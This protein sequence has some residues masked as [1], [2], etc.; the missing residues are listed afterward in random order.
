MQRSIPHEFI[1]DGIIFPGVRD[2]FIL[3]KGTFDLANCMHLF[4]T[5]AT[6]HGDDVLAHVNWEISEEW[7][8][9]YGYDMISR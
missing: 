1:I 6:V 4:M 9:K 5:S 2:K 3:Y 8:L 7:F